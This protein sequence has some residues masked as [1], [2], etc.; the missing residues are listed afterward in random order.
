MRI[1][2]N[3]PALSSFNALTGNTSA[4]QESIARLSKGLRIISAADDAAGLAI[5]EKMRAQ[6]R[7]LDQAARN[8]QDGISMI[9]TAE[10]ALNEGAS[11]LLRMRELSVQAAN[12]TLTSQDRGYI[13]LEIDQLK[14]ELDRISDTT[15]FN[16][17]KL[18]DGSADVLWS[19]SLEGT[20]LNVRGGIGGQEGNYK[21]TVFALDSGEG[22]VLKSNIFKVAIGNKSIVAGQNTLLR[23]IENFTDN[24]GVF[25]LESAQTISVSLE[26]GGEVS[27]TVYGDD[28]LGT[29]GEKLSAAIMDASAEPP[30]RGS[31][32]QFVGYEDVAP[33][34]KDP[35]LNGLAS[36]WLEGA[37][38]RVKDFYGLDGNGQKLTIA[39]PETLPGN[40]IVA[41]VLGSFDGK[42]TTI[43]MY[44]SRKNFLPATPPNGLNQ[45]GYYYNDRIVAHE[46]VHAVLVANPTLG[47]AVGNV[48]GSG[49]WLAEGL[50]EYIPGANDRVRWDTNDTN[51]SFDLGKAGTL[52]SKI[53][54]LLTAPSYDYD[55]QYDSSVAYSAAYLAVRYFDQESIKH[56][57]DKSKGVKGL[58]DALKGGFDMDTAIKMASGDKFAS[59]ADLATKL[60]TDAIAFITKV[61]G[62]DFLVD[63]GAIGGSYASGGAPLSPADVIGGSG[64]YKLN[65][66]EDYGWESVIWPKTAFSDGPQSTLAI[67]APKSDTLQSVEGTLLLHSPLAGSAGKI[68][69]SGDDGFISA[70][71]FAE[72]RAAREITYS[73][74]ISDAHSGKQVASNVKV[75]GRNILGVLHHNLD[76]QLKN[77]FALD[78]N[79]EGTLSD[80]Y[81]SFIFRQAGLSDFVMHVASNATVLQIG[82]N[83]GEDM[84]IS[85]GS[86]GSKALGVDEVR[87]L[88]RDLAARS[89]TLVDSA[90]SRVSSLRARL[91]SYQNRLEHTVTNLTA[92]STNLTAAEGRIR[93][94]DM[95]KEMMSFTK[96]NI[97]VQAGTSMLGQANQ[98]PRNLLQLVR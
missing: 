55:A 43:T 52:K 37:G 25:M 65:P 15:Q 69:I 39:I 72:V 32:V 47:G 58:F 14:S 92:A 51:G 77:N 34:K 53:N 64:T 76:I 70:L 1:L 68:T 9:Q 57:N 4:L 60:D 29:L 67:S 85:F 84:N 11:I 95:A 18:L 13:Q 6:I 45:E 63:T 59:R 3:I 41:Q 31:A 71:G 90:L 28:T 33:S 23:D 10:G 82:A 97:L 89:I 30:L 27:V 50:T 19:T 74:S 40:N 24:N 75:T 7:G 96:L 94:L 88:N 61:A 78:V 62:E 80:A 5:S 21:I 36:Y 73:V 83:E 38:R 20:R 35:I 49:V 16:K 8:S 44:V 66:L 22:Q 81:G 48:D 91:G 26:G 2:S 17:K 42:N 98:L 54:E 87:V 93:D 12:D 46:M 79:G 86:A 56:T